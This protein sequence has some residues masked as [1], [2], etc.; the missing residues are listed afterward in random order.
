MNL[1][2]PG[3]IH[4][5]P[6]QFDNSLKF[7]HWNLNGVCAPDKIKIPLLEAYNSIFH[8]DLIALSETNLNETVKNEDIIIDGFSTEIFRSDHPSGDEQ[9]GVCVYFKENLP[10]KRRKDLEI[11]QETVICEISLGREKGFLV[12]LCRSANQNNE[13]FDEFYHK[14]NIILIKLKT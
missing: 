7:C 10:I 12:A 4:P 5:K 3:D 9:G 1:C 11:L 14:L 6:G 8:Y 13:D 2:W